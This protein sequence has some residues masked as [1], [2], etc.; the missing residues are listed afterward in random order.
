[1]TLETAT[2]VEILLEIVGGGI[3]TILLLRKGQRLSVSA[4]VGGSLI[5]FGLIILAVGSGLLTGISIWAATGSALLILASSS[6][7]ALKK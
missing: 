7:L 5:V 4:G 1:M 3:I 6:Y 2:L